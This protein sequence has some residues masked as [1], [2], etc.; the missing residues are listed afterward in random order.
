MELSEKPGQSA[1]RR[2]GSSESPSRGNLC[3]RRV[4]SSKQARASN[5]RFS[6]WALALIAGVAAVWSAVGSWGLLGWDP[7]YYYSLMED[8]SWAEIYPFEQAMFW[9]IS[10]FRPWSFAS[11]EFFMIA[12]SLSI[13]LVSLYRLGYSRTDQFVLVFFFCCSF[14][15]LHFVLTFQRQ[16]FGLVLFLFSI[17]GRKYSIWARL[18]SLFSH[19]FTFTVHIFW[20]LRRLSARATAV[21]ALLFLPVAMALAG[22]FLNDKTGHYGDYG[23]DNPFHLMI[24]QSLTVGFCLVVL[25][26]LKNGE[27]ALRSLTTAYITL[28]LPVV[29]WPF[30]AGVFARLDYFF[31]PLIV[32]LWPRYVREDRRALCRV[33]IIGFTAIG[34]VL[35]MKLTAPCVVLSDCS[36]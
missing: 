21:V 4:Q 9:I 17:S 16:F 11:Y 31:L 27:G 3:G 15:G 24:K 13:L 10:A 32:V 14:Y 30:Y 25:F 18:V 33:S 19:L 29:L 7:H 2:P 20:E 28:S 12:T 26:T 5:R 34:F 23:V 1:V 35:W 22:S 36:P 6:I 8:K